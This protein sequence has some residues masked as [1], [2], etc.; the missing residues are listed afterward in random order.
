MTHNATLI[1]T[2]HLY[3]LQTITC[4]DDQFND[5]NHGMEKHM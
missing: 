5:N 4:I 2:V 3:T 1:N